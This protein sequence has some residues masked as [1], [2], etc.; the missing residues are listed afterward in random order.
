MKVSTRS[1]RK[2]TAIVEFALVGPLAFLLI[3]AIIAMG[4]AVW[5]YN[6][7]SEAVREGG[8]YATVHGSQSSKP[9]ALNNDTDVIATV[10][11]YCF[12]MDPSNLTVTSSCPDNH[13][14]TLV[15]VKVSYPY[16]W[17]FGLPLIPTL[18]LSSQTVMMIAH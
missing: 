12:V 2:G 8:R 9:I 1:T 10:K 4:L 17:W 14:G 7:L 15:T 18:T 11:N 16:K 13:A 5:T 3:F 6:N